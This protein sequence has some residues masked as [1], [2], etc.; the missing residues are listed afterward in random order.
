ML[1]S[2]QTP[3][4]RSLRDLD[5]IIVVCVLLLVGLGLLAIFS[6]TT[7]INTPAFLKGNFAKQVIWFTIGIMIASAVVMTPM[8]SFY[9][10]AYFF[11]AISLV[12]LILVLLVG[13][14][15]GAHRWFVLGPLRLQPSEIAK[16]ATILAVARFASSESTD[17][18]RHKDI[19][20]VFA[21][22]LVPALLIVK[23]PDLGTAIVFF[24]LAIPM[25]FWAGLSPFLIFVI[26]APIITLV[27]AFNV[28]TFT[29]VI[30]LITGVLIW[31]R[32]RLWVFLTIF[33]I[34]ITVGVLTPKLWGG[35]HEYQRTRILTFVGLQQDPKG[36]GYQVNQ[37]KVA[38]GS[39]GFWGKGWRQ[40]TQTKLRFLP[41]QHTD[42]IFSVVGEEFGFFGVTLVL[43]VFWTL[44]W[45]ALVI[46]AAVKSKFT[47]LVVVGCVTGISVHIIIN[48]GMSVGIMP[49]TGL[50]LPFLSYGGSA[51]WTNMVLIALILNAGVRR[52]QYL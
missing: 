18:R 23:E 36:T 46:A 50:P 22:V 17:V 6:A 26:T 37:S 1:P 14:G 42:F 38:I 28:Y 41:E 48:T 21:L 25:L 3:Y 19:A 7:A 11:Y 29:A 31:R 16:V 35:L 47:A 4:G 51:L 2:E 39:G 9:K 5:K 12:L 30:L 34:N 15:K 32:S 8:K 33:L 45:R 13:T 27:S 24:S 52:F 10:F 49:V 44:L 20:I 43:V 40:G